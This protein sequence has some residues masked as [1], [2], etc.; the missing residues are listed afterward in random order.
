MNL[1]FPRV[2]MAN[3]NE[4]KYSTLKNET[5]MG[6]IRVNDNNEAITNIQK[7]AG[8][9]ALVIGGSLAGLFAARVLA[10]YFETVTILDHDIFPV[11][12]DHRKGVPQSYHAHGLL[13]TAFPILEQLF[14]G[15]MIDLRASGAATASNMVPLAIVSPKGLLPLPK[16]SGEFIAFSR[17]LLEWHVRDRVSARSE[18]HI[19][20]NTEVTGLL[21]TQDRTRVIGIKMRERGQ[22]GRTTTL[23]ADLVVDASGRYSKAPQWLVELGYES[24]PVETIN[25]NLRYASR[26]YA[27]PEQ[28]PAEWQSLIVS[29]RPPH[30]N[31]GLILS[32]DHGRW[33]VTLGGMAGNV[34]PTDEEGFLQWARDLPDPSIYEALRI[35]QPLTPIRGYGTPENHMR[36]FERMHR[37]PTGFIVTGD[38]VCAFNPIYGQGMTVSALD[39]MILKR[40]LQE[41]QRSPIANFEQYFQQQLAPITASAWL[42]ATNQDLRW[43]TVRLR[44]ARPNPA[45]RLLHSY[46]DLVL[47]SAIVNPEIAQAYFNVLILAIAPRSL[48]RPRMVARVLAVAFKRAVRRLF[49]R[50][51]DVGFALSP[52]ALSTLRSRAGISSKPVS[53]IERKM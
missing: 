12:P 37:W 25:S 43:P 4:L 6:Q 28:F 49:C 3:K 21:A 19:I 5:Q 39:A 48:V 13:A 7:N 38:A 23:H 40:C 29:M 47:F 26:F 1:C 2:Y 15:I 11:T 44:G 16:N 36:H 51:E 17:P 42:I 30:E 9:H 31:A 32:V 50:Q 20:V 35:A 45:L 33:H 53:F 41:Q 52:E 34:P 46:L 24:P 8:S 18:V 14:P 10:D 22:E 27:K